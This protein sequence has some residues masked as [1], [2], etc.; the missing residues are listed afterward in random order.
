MP[1]RKAAAEEGASEEEASEEEASEEEAGA[2]QVMVLLAAA[3]EVGAALLE[4]QK[5]NCCPAFFMVYS[6]S[7]RPSQACAWEIGSA[8][9]LEDG[10]GRND[11]GLGPRELVRGGEHVC[12][13]VGWRRQRQLQPL[14][15]R[16]GIS[17]C[18]DATDSLNGRVGDEL[19]G[20]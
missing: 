20:A 19:E 13:D 18:W 14:R 10:G 6:P 16:G 1:G 8:I 5:P 4:V 15:R 7:M 17:L 12:V 2:L 3:V 11:V 9:D